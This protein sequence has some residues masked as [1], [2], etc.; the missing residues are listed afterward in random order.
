MGQRYDTPTK[1]SVE[2]FGHCMHKQGT[3]FGRLRGGQRQAVA[4]QLQGRG[5]KQVFNMLLAERPVEHHLD[6]NCSLCGPSAAALRK[7]K[8]AAGPGKHGSLDPFAAVKIDMDQIRED[9]KQQCLRSNR[10]A[11]VY[12]WRQAML[13]L[14]SQWMLAFFLDWHVYVWVVAGPDGDQVLFTPVVAQDPA[15]ARN[16]FLKGDQVPGPLLLVQL[17]HTLKTAQFVQEGVGQFLRIV[18]K[19]S[20]STAAI[21]SRPCHP[22]FLPQFVFID[23]DQALI[24][25]FALLL[26]LCS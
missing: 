10:K 17:V 15:S 19:T 24:N 2:F 7:V 11:L 21:D 26:N 16:S 5:T 20:Q 22:N 18:G 23:H 14:D 6:G 12:G 8:S 13:H 25:G 4:A 3:V 9:D 1:L